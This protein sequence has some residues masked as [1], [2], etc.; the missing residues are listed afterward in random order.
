MMS[1]HPS[2]KT[3]PCL[4]PTQPE[5]PAQPMAEAPRTLGGDRKPASTVPSPGVV[6]KS[7]RGRYAVHEKRG[8]SADI[9]GLVKDLSSSQP[10]ARVLA[11]KKLKEYA[12]DAEKA[13][14]V[15]SLLPPDDPSNRMVALVR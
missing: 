8:Q 12:T 15:V 2:R 4:A 7:Q 9:K 1:K 10:D 13:R 11:A 5:F 14:N 3:K 6:R